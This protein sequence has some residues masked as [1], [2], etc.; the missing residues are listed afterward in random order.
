VSFR[1]AAVA[2]CATA[3]EV[4]SAIL[5]GAARFCRPVRLVDRPGEM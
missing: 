3:Y 4:P 5:P 2:G 1:L